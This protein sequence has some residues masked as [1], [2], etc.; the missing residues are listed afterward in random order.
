MLILAAIITISLFTPMLF[1]NP[2]KVHWAWSGDTWNSTS[3]AVLESDKLEHL[4]GS[5][6][7]YFILYFICATPFQVFLYCV[8]F[9]VI[10]EIKDSILDWRIYGWYGGDGF[11]WRD[12][13][14]DIVGFLF[15]ADT[16]NCGVRITELW[17]G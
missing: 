14:A 15:M 13:V 10:W 9:G 16:I 2:G 5:M 7:L 4:F 11:S 12:L 3:G 17:R 8:Y 1:K 6:I